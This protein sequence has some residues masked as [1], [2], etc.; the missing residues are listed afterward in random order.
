MFNFKE[1]GIDLG[2][3]SIK[4][5][6]IEK[7]DR[8][9]SLN[10]KLIHLRK[11]E[12]YNV[13]CEPY[14]EKY[15]QLLKDCI[16][17]FSKKYKIKLLSI[18]ISIPVDKQISNVTF[19]NMPIVGDKLLNDG[20]SFEAEEKMASEGISNSHYAW[21]ISNEYEELSEYEILLST[22]RKDVISALSQFKSITWKLNR[23][24]LQ[25]ILL[26]RVV[27]SNDVIIDLGHKS[28]RIYIYTKGKLSKVE[29][30]ETGGQHLLSNIEEYIK[31]NV[32]YN[33]NNI[34]AKDIIK[35]I[36]IYNERIQDNFPYET[37]PLLEKQDNNN[38]KIDEAQDSLSYQDDDEYKDQVKHV[39]YNNELIL[40]L[41]KL[42]S[43]DT[44]RLIDE[45]KRII[46]MY[47]LE[48]GLNIDEVYYVGELSKLTYFKESIES[49]LDIE[50]KPVDVLNTINDDENAFLYA[51][52]GLV[53]M[54]PHLKDNT[55]FVKYIR[56]NIDY[57]LIIIGLLTLSLS[58]GLSL[59]KVD[60]KYDIIRDNLNEIIN[61]QNQTTRQLEDNMNEINKDINNNDKF[62]NRMESLSNEKKW[63]SDILYVIPDKTPITIAIKQMEIIDKKVVLTGYSSNYSSVGFFAN[64][65]EK[66]GEVNIN[67]ISDYNNGD[68]EIYSV[69]MDTPE[70]IS[71]D[72]KA[73]KLFTITLNYNNQLLEH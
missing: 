55:D 25:P 18:N 63:L 36:S 41:S 54:D 70:L 58:V 42:I 37:S 12:V 51:M 46:R 69:T 65:L 62:I 7:Q 66:I 8:F 24:L 45:I 72:F 13:D 23:F 52:A 26:E 39:D 50:L 47:E 14:T 15:Y 43:K 19:F 4:I 10:L 3:Y 44:D 22:V 73:T 60:K 57:T 32:T 16:K 48:N 61:E 30:I 1:I 67:S 33:D 6:T 5:A 31:N 21:K 29:T 35:S 34:N 56:S 59:K 64:E 71:D 2:S 17:K 49:E 53:S 38:A 68:G 20:V 9:N 28:T 27:S 40:E 11:H